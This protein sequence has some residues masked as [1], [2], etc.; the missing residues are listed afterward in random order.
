[1]FR[2]EVLNENDRVVSVADQVALVT[3]RLVGSDM[4]VRSR[5]GGGQGYKCGQ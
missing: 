5:E 4:S 1:M 3:D 2:G